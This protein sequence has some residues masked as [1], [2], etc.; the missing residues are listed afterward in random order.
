[1]KGKKPT[2]ESHDGEVQLGANVSIQ[3]RE[4]ARGKS[5][6]GGFEMDESFK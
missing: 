1:M 4:N 3:T 2:R 6:H 5:F